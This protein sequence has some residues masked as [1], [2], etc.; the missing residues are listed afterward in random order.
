MATKAIVTTEGGE[1]TITPTRFEVD[2]DW[3]YGPSVKHLDG[4]GQPMVG[5]DWY[6][7]YLQ[8]EIF[9]QGDGDPTVA[10]RFKDGKIA[11]ICIPRS[12]QKMIRYEDQ[13]SEW[14][15]ERDSKRRATRPR[16][17]A[18]RRDQTTPKAP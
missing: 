8:F 17:N 4:A 6:H 13:K 10:I 2:M 1:G 11:E 3:V 5:A 9:E 15:Q 14:Q 12:M 18:D 16:R 7:D